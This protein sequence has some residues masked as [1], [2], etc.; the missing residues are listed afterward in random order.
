MK[1][2]DVS[3]FVC[4]RQTRMEDLPAITAM[5]ET[6]YPREEP[7][8]KKHL[9]S[10]LEVFPDGQF[11]AED[12]R[13]G[14]VVG[15][16]SSLIVRWDDYAFGDDWM[17]FTE[18]G[19]FTNHDPEHGRTLY[20]ADIMVDP[21]CQGMGIGKKIYAA[22]RDL[23]RRFGLPRIRAG[24]RLRGYG[25]YADQMSAETYVQ[26]V[27]NRELTDPTLSFQLKQG[28]R[29]LAVIKGYLDADPAS[30]GYA[31]AI[32][33]IN[34]Q[35]AQRGDYRGRDPR[36]ARHRHRPR[37]AP[38]SPSPPSPPLNEGASGENAG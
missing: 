6:I 27:V 1:K 25:R 28:F 15:M 20:G 35:V 7:W 32:E 10:H 8:E 37:H 34:H 16:A 21:A 4:I 18:G 3:S 2:R 5:G 22:R 30:R 31:A 17:H 14:R 12:T 36:F 29:V 23:C 33:W 24:A 38:P 13:T 19:F 11:V 9:A 26:Q